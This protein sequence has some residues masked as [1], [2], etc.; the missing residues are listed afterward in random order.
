MLT[1][2]KWIP[3]A[4]I[5]YFST[6]HIHWLPVYLVGQYI[7]FLYWQLGKI[8]QTILKRNQKPNVFLLP[9]LLKEGIVKTELT[10][11]R[12]Q[13]HQNPA[14]QHP[15]SCTLLDPVQRQKEIPSHLYQ[16]HP[17]TPHLDANP[18]RSEGSQF[19]PRNHPQQA[20]HPL[21]A[22]DMPQPQLQHP[23][24][25][26]RPQH[27]IQCPSPASL[28]NAW[29]GGKPYQLPC[30]SGWFLVVSICDLLYR[31]CKRGHHILCERKAREKYKSANFHVKPMM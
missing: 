11:T 2:N 25:R 12:N 31:F 26:I 17:P 8:S 30:R 18:S 28:P 29:R 27:Q 1:Q 16:L 5:L 15:I 9:V 14:S 19:K 3:L 23:S 21:P 6:Q 4:T 24:W 13:K 22:L 20:H 10:T 7:L